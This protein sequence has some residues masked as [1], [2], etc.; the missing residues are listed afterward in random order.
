LAFEVGPRDFG[1]ETATF[2]GLCPHRQRAHGV[3]LPAVL[4][5]GDPQHRFRLELPW[6]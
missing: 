2:L 5:E 3:A 6:G 1:D 4:G